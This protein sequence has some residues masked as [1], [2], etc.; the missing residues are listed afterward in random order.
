MILQG[1]LPAAPSARWPVRCRIAIW[2]LNPNPPSPAAPLPCE[3]AGLDRYG[4]CRRKQ[5]R[6]WTAHDPTCYHQDSALILPKQAGA[7]QGVGLAERIGPIAGRRGRFGRLGQNLQQQR[8]GRVAG[9]DAGKVRPR[10]QQRKAAGRLFGLGRQRGIQAQQPAQLAGAADALGQDRLPVGPAGRNSVRF[11]IESATCHNGKSY[12]NQTTTES[13]TGK[14]VVASYNT[15]EFRKGLKVQLDGDPY[16]MIECN[17]VKPGKGQALYKC[18]LRNLLRGTVLDR[19][20]KSGD[21]LD[22]AEIDEIQAQFLYRQQDHFVFMDNESYEQYELTAEQVDDAWKYL[23]EGM[24]CSIVLHNNQPISITPPN[25]VVLR[26][27]YCEPG[28][29]GNTA[30]NVT[31]PCKVETGAEF[32]CPVFVNIGDLIKIDTRTG[33]YLERVKE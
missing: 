30:T 26:V 5:K 10:H 11:V 4:K 8:V 9:T 27:E 21:S 22:A 12:H 7:A 14:T 23:K 16:I 28:A 20:Y 29:K 17:F 18:K 24:V 32:P 13:E 6:Q 25:H 31:K 1:R 33:E 2:S 15:S 19:T 3:S